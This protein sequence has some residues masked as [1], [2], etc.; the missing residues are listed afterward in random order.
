MKQLS[1]HLRVF[2]SVA[3]T[4]LLLSWRFVYICLLISGNDSYKSSSFTYVLIIR[5]AKPGYC[6]LFMSGMKNNEDSVCGD[7]DVYEYDDSDAK[8]QFGCVCSCT[9]L[10]AFKL[11]TFIFNF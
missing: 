9:R 5:S 11:L 4:T 1:N 10:Y 3:V 6:R 7:N 2:T 8:S